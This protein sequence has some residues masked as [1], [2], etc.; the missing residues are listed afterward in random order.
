MPWYFG[1]DSNNGTPLPTCGDA[2]PFYIGGLGQGVTPGGAFDM[3]AA[4]AAGP[5]LTFSYWFLEGP[6]SPN[7]PSSDT[8]RAWGIAQ[9]N[10]YWQTWADDSSFLQGYTLFADIEEGYGWGTD[11]TANMEV[12]TGWLYQLIENL[13]VGAGVY[14]S[15][16]NWQTYFNANFP[17]EV[18]LWLA[19]T[20]CP[21]TCADAESQFP[22]VASFGGYKVMIWQCVVYNPSGSTCP[23]WEGQSNIQDI[24]I[25]PYNGYLNGQWNPTPA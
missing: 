1:T 7:K 19:G 24:N 23:T 9:A 11:Q 17:Y 13:V 5:Q 12:L 16:S 2:S 18:V 3:T 21:S 4:K 14:I 15:Y 10:A 22:P 20:N 25:T 6:D 8:N